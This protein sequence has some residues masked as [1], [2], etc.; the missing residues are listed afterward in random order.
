MTYSMKIPGCIQPSKMCKLD[1][2]ISG[3][4]KSDYTYKMDEK[5]DFPGLRPLEQFA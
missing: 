1:N 2:F 3:F 4:M 5:S